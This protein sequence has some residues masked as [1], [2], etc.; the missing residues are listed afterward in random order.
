MLPCS[1]CILSAVAVEQGEAQV[2]ERVRS[3]PLP[4]LT[5]PPRDDV[6]GGDGDDDCPDGSIK[7]L[8]KCRRCF[9]AVGD[10]CSDSS[11]SS[12]ICGSGD[13]CVTRGS[14]AVRGGEIVYSSTIT[15]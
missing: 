6:E 3:W 9:L 5:L 2:T 4:R 10:C 7:A 8:P 15:V 1:A 13:C 11:D 12:A 14:G